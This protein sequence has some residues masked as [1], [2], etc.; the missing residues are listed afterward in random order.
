MDKG[1]TTRRYDENKFRRFCLNVE[2]IQT[3]KARELK[4]TRKRG[5][6]SARVLNRPTLID[7]LHG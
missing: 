3:Q 4:R 1:L 2:Q 5:R 6:T 7:A